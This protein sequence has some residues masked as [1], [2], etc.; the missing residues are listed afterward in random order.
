MIEIMIVVAIIALLATVALVASYG[1]AR[2]ASRL[3]PMDALREE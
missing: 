2:R 1:P 3:E